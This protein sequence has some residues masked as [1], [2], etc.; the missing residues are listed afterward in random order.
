TTGWT[1]FESLSDRAI[2]KSRPDP[3]KVP[4]FALFGGIVSRRNTPLRVIQS[5]S[6]RKSAGSRKPLISRGPRLLFQRPAARTKKSRKMTRFSRPKPG[7]AE[8]EWQP[9]Q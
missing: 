4:C 5:K 6:R 1:A 2:L 7:R 3:E 9:P 8:H